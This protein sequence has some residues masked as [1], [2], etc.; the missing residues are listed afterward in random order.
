MFDFEGIAPKFIV[1]CFSIHLHSHLHICIDRSRDRVGSQLLRSEVKFGVKEAL[2]FLVMPHALALVP[3]F[4][5]QLLVTKVPVKHELEFPFVGLKLDCV[6][7]G[8]EGIDCVH[9][10]KLDDLNAL[11]L[12]KVVLTL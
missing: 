11:I 10:G 3:K 5:G 1:V 7:D 6:F 12:L 8:P 2:F 9:V 4:K